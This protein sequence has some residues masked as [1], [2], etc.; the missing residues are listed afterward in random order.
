MSSWLCNCFFADEWSI[1]GDL[2]S[3]DSAV[4]LACEGQLAII[5][6]QNAKQ[7]AISNMH[8]GPMFSEVMGK[9]SVAGLKAAYTQ[10]RQRF[11]ENGNCRGLYSVIDVPL[12]VT[13]CNCRF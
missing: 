5:A 3:V 4:P 6:Q 11:R 12:N 10:Y 8:F 13:D 2:L 9:I 7:N 1:V